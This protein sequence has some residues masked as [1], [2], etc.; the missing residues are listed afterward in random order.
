M[1][2]WAALKERYLRD[3]L[4]IRIGGLAANLA[5]VKSFSQDIEHCELVEGLLQESKYFIEW[6][7]PDA[8]IETAAELVELQRQLVRWQYHWVK[9]WNDPE[10][11]LNVAEQAKDWSD[12]VLDLSGL[13]SES[14]V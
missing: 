6:T 7:A 5:R 8:E 11:R 12:R 13:L 9:I 4:P 3:E 14:S 1:R 10:Q 2:N